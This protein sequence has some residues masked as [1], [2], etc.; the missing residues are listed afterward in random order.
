MQGSLGCARG[1]RCLQAS[2]GC[3][4]AGIWTANARRQTAQQCAWCMQLHAC[5]CRWLD[6]LA[7]RQTQADPSIPESTGHVF[8]P[9]VSLHG[10]TFEVE[11][12]TGFTVS[13]SCTS[14]HK[15]D[16]IQHKDTFPACPH[17]HGLLCVYACHH[18]L[19]MQPAYRVMSVAWSCSHLQC[20]HEESHS[21]RAAQLS[22]SWVKRCRPSLHGKQPLL[23]DAGLT[24]RCCAGQ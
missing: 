9:N 13:V 10:W 18:L 24:W 5:A 21:S 11:A 12:T 8:H 7:A 20:V 2:T 1:R 19:Q 23:W 14:C 15:F 16:M 6:I 22:I 3:F 17:K 4:G